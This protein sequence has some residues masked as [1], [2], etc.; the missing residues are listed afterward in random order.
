VLAGEG[1]R[2]TRAK[3][4]KGD[5]AV[6][7]HSC[8]QDAQEWGALTVLLGPRKDQGRLDLLQSLHVVDAGNLSHPVHNLLK[9]LQV[10]DF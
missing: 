5:D 6:E 2:A 7:S 3:E 4:P 10:G 1:A 8:A 9:M